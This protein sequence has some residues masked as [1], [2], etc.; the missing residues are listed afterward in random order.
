MYTWMGTD[1]REQRK[2]KR[3]T[4]PTLQRDPNA[5]DVDVIATTLNAMNIKEREKFMREGL[6]FHCRKPGHI[7]RDCPLK[8]GNVQILT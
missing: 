3:R 5:M 7:S 2:K 8:K 4:T 1:D 6:C